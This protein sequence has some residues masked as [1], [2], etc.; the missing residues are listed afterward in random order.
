MAKP[1]E[2]GDY[3]YASKKDCIEYC[4][5]LI[6][7]YK[8]GDTLPEEDQIYFKQLLTLHP[9]YEDKVGCGVKS[10]TYDYSATFGSK[11]LHIIRYDGSKEAT[12]WKSCL[13]KPKPENH[14]ESALRREVCDDVGAFK[15]KT[16]NRGAEC[17]VSGEELTYDNC[18][19]VY[20][21]DG[22]GLTF[23]QLVAKF[24]KE[25][26]IEYTNVNLRFPTDNAEDARPQLT[27]KELANKWVAFHNDNAKITLLSSD[28]SMRRKK[29]LKVL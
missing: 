3:K 15:S 11:C 16:C 18:H 17:P 5:A 19:A 20:S 1:I 8:V 29:T 26:G 28:S 24:Y 12:S 6:A 2:F 13:S 14:V 7:K 4:E 27:D 23:K 21:Y 22:K 10:I 25:Q 9:D